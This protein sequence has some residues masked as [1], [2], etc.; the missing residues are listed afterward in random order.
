MAALAK[1]RPRTSPSRSLQWLRLRRW[2]V[3]AGL[4]DGQV[5]VEATWEVEPGDYQVTIAKTHRTG[6]YC[7][8]HSVDQP[9][10]YSNV[11]MEHHSVAI[12]AK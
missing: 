12:T 8:P 6:G 11:D 10:Y 1:V 7:F 5:T 4:I 3:E 9:R 2:E